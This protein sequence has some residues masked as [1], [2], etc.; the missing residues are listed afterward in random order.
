M[1]SLICFLLFLTLILYKAIT[2]DASYPDESGSIPESPIF[3]TDLNSDNENPA[4]HP[5]IEIRF[6]YIERNVTPRL[7]GK[8]ILIFFHL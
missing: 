8:N 5:G 3:A 2:I 4:Q 6:V 7:Y 1:V